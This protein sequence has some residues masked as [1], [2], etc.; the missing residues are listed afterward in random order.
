MALAGGASFGATIGITVSIRD[1]IDKAIVTHQHHLGRYIP[2]L[3]YLPFAGFVAGFSL[4]QASSRVGFELEYRIRI[5]LYE[6][7]QALDPRHLDSV[8]TGQLVTRA[9]T[10]LS[11]LELFAV[12]VPQLVVIFIV[13]AAIAVAIVVQSI[14]MGA[15]AIFGVPVN[16]WIVLRFRRRLLGLSWMA[17]HRR[18]EVTTT[19]DEAVRGIR[20]VKSFGREDHER[21]RVRERAVAA[22][23]VAM[24][25]IRAL[26][27]LDLVL[28]A[29]PAVLTSLQLVV[30]GRLIAGSNF[31]IGRLLVLLYF[32]AALT[33][34]AQSFA[35]IA[36]AWQ[37]A[38]AG[39]VRLTE[40]MNLLGD[41]DDGEFRT[42]PPPST[43]L[44]LDGVGFETGGRTLLADVNL[45]VAPG[46][47]VVLHGPPGAGKSL[48]ASLAAGRVI[49]TAGNVCLD[50]VD[51][52]ELAPLDVA[53]AV[54]VLA[55][56]PFLFG[57]SVRENLQIGADDLVADATLWRALEAAGAAQV[58]RDL[59]DGLDT[60]LG[61]RGMTLSGGQRQ[62]VAL[63]RALL[64][65]PRV[66]V[67]DDAL[68]AVN[69][70]LELEIVRGM[71]ELAPRTAILCITRR[72]GL[73][74]LADRI[75]TLPARDGSFAARP[76]VTTAP[77]SA[78]AGLMEAAMAVLSTDPKLLEAVQS[79][80]PDRDAPHVS[81]VAAVESDK[82][83]TVLHVVRPIARM[84]AGALALLLVVTAANLAPPGLYKMATDDFRHHTHHVGDR[85]ALFLLLIAVIAGVS[86]YFF[87]L[88]NGRVVQEVMYLLQRRVFQRLSRL[89]ID[90]YDR[91]LPGQVAARVVYDLDRISG[92]MDGGLYN[93][94]VNL[95]VIVLSMVVI[96]VWS[97][98]VA[99][100]VLPFV[101]VLLILS[102]VQIPIA[103]RAYDR[104]RAELGKVVERLQ[105]DM[106]G[107]YVI[108]AFGKRSA[109]M[110]AFRDRALDLRFA[111]RWSAG[112]S[113][114]YIELMTMVGLLAAGVLI[115]KA[116]GLAR[117]GTLSVGSMIALEVYLLIAIGSIAFFADAVQKLM[118]A[119]ASFRTVRRPFTAPILPE[120]R[121]DARACPPLAGDLV[122]SHVG[123][124]YPGTTRRVL[125]DVCLEIA[126]GTSLALVGPTGA[127]KSSIAKLIARIYDPVSGTVRADGA[128][129]RDLD[130]TAYR[131]RLG[132]VPQDAFCFRGT[133]GDNVA[134][135]A[136]DASAEEIAAAVD[137]VGGSGVLASLA[138]GMATQVDEE[139]RNLTAAQRQVIALARAVLTNPD[140]LILDEATSSLDAATE[141]AVLGAVRRMGRTTIFITHR[142][143]VARTADRVAVVDGGA[144]VEQGTHDELT[145]L[146]RA[147]ATL[148]A[149]GP[150][151]EADTVVADP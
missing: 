112:V 72:E 37:F 41:D 4:R 43:G 93:L 86:N 10:D 65:A 64:V 127:G 66:L 7:L 48:T 122:L 138:G 96:L 16:I 67:L 120:E 144:I 141:E 20:V 56:E 23:A 8:A 29:L 91:E 74:G 146:G 33:G 116:G 97:P 22:Y 136:P 14:P 75:E 52:Q 35:D 83:P 143:P 125:D 88:A 131:R 77:A 71:R 123:F 30:A 44:R 124:A 58:I 78:D 25:R 26:A 61:D 114:A 135:G 129:L 134:Y 110:G 28:R 13:I 36:D 109:A 24:N 79:L 111:R 107:R 149:V 130:L 99:Y 45:H 128:D 142:L 89:G 34:F 84:V 102:G 101:P 76:A 100:V 140:V 46:E 118:A 62:R 47:L 32:A 51:V 90:Y 133:V 147:Y 15:L 59:P 1:A 57:R 137:A 11:F 151:I 39:A 6:R 21:G 92:F 19:I 121:A 80:P 73:E 139:G 106:A 42:M 68:S 145:A 40:L 105:E 115:W 5:R 50:G 81:D 18:A 2:P 27:Q 119:R 87:R 103:D 49:P 108:D 9:V 38:K 3:L 148:W 70:A 95:S 12:L 126:P 54:R 98:P 63:A 132:I 53:R 113:N 69:P 31:T 150:E 60:V 104:Q 94:S 82:E 55:E 85:A 17:L 117:A